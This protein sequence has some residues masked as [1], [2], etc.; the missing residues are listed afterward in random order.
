MRILK[1][2]PVYA[3]Q[4]LLIS[5][6]TFENVGPT[7]VGKFLPGVPWNIGWKVSRNS[8]VRGVLGANPGA[9][10]SGRFSQGFSKVARNITTNI[11]S[12]LGAKPGNFRAILQAI[13]KTSRRLSVGTSVFWVP[14]SPKQ[15]M[16]WGGWLSGFQLQALVERGGV[17]V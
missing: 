16:G 14:T 13:F 3:M 2:L 4:I 8:G 9:K 17:F 7:S 12:I 1:M 11:G 6:G 10:T 5:Q 15:G